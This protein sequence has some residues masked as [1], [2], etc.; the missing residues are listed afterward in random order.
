MALCQLGLVLLPESTS[1]PH[2]TKS[3][4]STNS[5]PQTGTNL[6]QYLHRTSKERTRKYFNISFS[7]GAYRIYQPI[8]DSSELNSPHPT[9]SK[10]NS[11]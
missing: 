9:C 2:I 4:A 5:Q 8:P 7:N 10:G 6:T 11:R 1:A 3:N